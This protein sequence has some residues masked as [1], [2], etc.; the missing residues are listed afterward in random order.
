MDNNKINI[1][2]QL[3]YTQMLEEHRWITNL[4]WNKIH[5]LIIVNGILF[6]AFNLLALQ[7][8]KG[9]YYVQKISISIV[10]VFITI[11]WFFTLNHSIKYKQNYRNQIIT[12]QNDYPNL[13]INFLDDYKSWKDTFGTDNI[14]KISSFGLIILWLILILGVKIGYF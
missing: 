2:N 10:G 5:T 14:T 12:I 8:L 3:K 9:D 7:G 1:D 11:I 13:S 4:I 6:S